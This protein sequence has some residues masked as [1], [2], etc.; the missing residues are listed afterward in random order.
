[1]KS[2]PI[3]DF[4]I[5]VNELWLKQWFLLTSG[6]YKSNHMIHLP[7]ALLTNHIKKTFP[8]LAQNQVVMEIKLYKPD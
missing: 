3:K 1:M 6:D 4:L 5:R 2:I 7:S 8:Y